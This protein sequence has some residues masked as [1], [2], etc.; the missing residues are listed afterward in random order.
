MEILPKKKAQLTKKWFKF[1]RYDN[2]FTVSPK[3]FPLNQYE[4]I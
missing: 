1:V 2:S 3:N 4:F